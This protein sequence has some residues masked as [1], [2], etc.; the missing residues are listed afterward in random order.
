MLA[1]GQVGLRKSPKEGSHGDDTPP[2][3][4]VRA[5]CF[6]GEVCE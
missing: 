5:M 3:V 1:A 4:A 6:S 2:E